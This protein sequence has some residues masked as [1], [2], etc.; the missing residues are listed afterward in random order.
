M[1]I[2][3]NSLS[4]YIDQKS[5]VLGKIITNLTEAVAKNT[6]STNKNTI[7]KFNTK[8]LGVLLVRRARVYP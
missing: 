5:Y 1:G 7:N 2:H 6:T 3:L 4:P 8:N